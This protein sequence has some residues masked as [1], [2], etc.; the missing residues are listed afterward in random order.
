LTVLYVPSLSE[1][2]DSDANR[3]VSIREVNAF[4]SAIPP[5]WSLPQALAYW[6][7]GKYFFCFVE[8]AQLNQSQGWRVDCRYYSARIEQA[9]ESMIR[10]QADAL[11]ENRRCIAI[12]LDSYTID[13]LPLCPLLHA[14]IDTYR[15]TSNGSSV[16]LQ[17]STQRL[18]TQISLNWLLG[19]AGP[20]R[21]IWLINLTP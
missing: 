14:V 20:R 18:P 13:G 19:V 15:Q 17:S 5:D 6:A 4:T 7:A 2:F 8:F 1:G 12:Y 9:I 16:L 11:P 10:A 3:L 21:K